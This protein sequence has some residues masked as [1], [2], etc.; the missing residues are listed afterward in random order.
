MQYYFKI[1]TFKQ[2]RMTQEPLECLMF[3]S[4]S[5]VVYIN[6]VWPNLLGLKAPLAPDGKEPLP[7]HPKST[8]KLCASRWC[9]KETCVSNIAVKSPKKPLAVHFHIFSCG[10]KTKWHYQGFEGSPPPCRRFVSRVSTQSDFYHRYL[11]KFYLPR[12]HHLNF[13]HF[14][15]LLYPIHYLQATDTSLCVILLQVTSPARQFDRF[16]R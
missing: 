7:L 11:G 14:F 6:K 12:C 5:P 2:Y 16:C 1:L 3:R 13:Y 4:N 9:K 8:D 15:L 10:E